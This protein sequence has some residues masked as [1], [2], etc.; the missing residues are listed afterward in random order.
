MDE[1]LEQE[2]CVICS[3]ALDGIQETFCQMCGG[4]FHQPWTRDSALPQCGHIASH[5]EALAVVFLCN[6]CYYGQRP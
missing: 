3:G 1:E 6:D 5:E 2:F 4:K